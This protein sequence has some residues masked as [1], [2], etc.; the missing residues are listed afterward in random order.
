MS[1]T[2]YGGRPHYQADFELADDLTPDPFSEEPLPHSV[3]HAK[4][5]GSGNRK[6]GKVN[7][8]RNQEKIEDNARK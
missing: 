6:S 7:K 3:P 2:S 8:L 4:R 1:R 5:A